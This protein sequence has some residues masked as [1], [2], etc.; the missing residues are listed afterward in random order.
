MHHPNHQ[1]RSIFGPP[2]RSRPAG[3]MA[4]AVAGVAAVALLTGCASSTDA[5]TPDDGRLEALAAFYPLQFVAERVGGDLVDVT[6]LTPPAAE[7]HDLELSPAQVR[8]VGEVDLVLY[9]EGMQPATDE[10]VA[11]RAPEHVVDASAVVD[12]TTGGSVAASGDPHFWL[13]PTLLIPV[14]HAVADELAAVDPD[15]ADAYAAGADAL[16]DDLTAL[17]G[18]MESGLAAC[19]GATVVT[20]HEAF[21][22]L[23]DR[24]GLEQVGIAGIDPEVEPSPAR[25]RDVR[26][27][28]EQEGVETLFFEVATSSSVTA[29]LANDLGVATDVLDPLE[30]RVDDG[31][32]Y[33][34]IMRANLAALESGLACE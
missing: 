3:V 11:A 19:Q 10:A 22:Y 14:G 34:E 9:L 2:R 13:D 28:V 23:A 18:E 26:D 21:G 7:P 20:S 32:D 8:S 31:K 25:L 33:L 30:S 6:N 24:Y 4:G 27:V 16:A 29:R 15:N 17:D 5:G 12:E 1:S